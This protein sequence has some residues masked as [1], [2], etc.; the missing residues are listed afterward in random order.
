MSEHEEVHLPR[1]TFWPVVLGAGISLAAFGV[2]TSL[3]FTALGVV[4]LAWG[5]AGWVQD[6]R[7]EP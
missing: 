4:M 1:P 2:A 7:H 5:L 6:L 3:L